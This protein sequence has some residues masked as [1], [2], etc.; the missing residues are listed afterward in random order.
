MSRTRFVWTGYFGGS[1]P[2]GPSD[3]PAVQTVISPTAG[4]PSRTIFQVHSDQLWI[5]CL[6]AYYPSF[7]LK[8][9]RL[10]AKSCAF[11][12]THL[13]SVLTTSPPCIGSRELTIVIMNSRLTNIL[14]TN[15]LNLTRK[16]L[17]EPH[18][19]YRRRIT[20]RESVMCRRSLAD[21]PKVGVVMRSGLQPPAER[22]L[23]PL[24]CR[25]SPASEI[26]SLPHSHV[27]W[28]ALFPPR[29]SEGDRASVGR[30]AGPERNARSSS[31]AVR[32][33]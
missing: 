26:V 6:H 25:R 23:T 11:Q 8:L 10:L 1:R 3:S 5:A 33:P 24:A 2:P 32:P 4:D 29:R 30:W 28:L 9:L 13:A 20:C 21:A 7:S 15:R 22:T 31:R 17:V 14:T 27:L 12:P 18:Q 19:R 16:V